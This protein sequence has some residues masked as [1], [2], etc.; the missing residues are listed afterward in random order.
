MH[1]AS[2]KK[3]LLL[4][5]ALLIATIVF[6]TT[7]HELVHLVVGRAFGVPARFLN[8]TSVGVPP[9]DVHRYPEFSLAMMNAIAPI[10]SVLVFG[11]LPIN[12]IGA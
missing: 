12:P 6:T 4:R 1:H 3:D 9:S 7:V 10:F 2:M 11:L 5:S 8:F